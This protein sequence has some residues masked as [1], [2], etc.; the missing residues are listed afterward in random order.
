M[1]GL[2]DIVMR[3][4]DAGCD[5]QLIADM[6]DY[7]DQ[8]I[9]GAQAAEVVPSKGAE[10][11][12]RWREKQKASQNVTCDVTSDVTGD[13]S[14]ETLPSPDVPPF[15]SPKPPSHNPPLPPIQHDTA[16]GEFALTGEIL[17]PSPSPTTAKARASP[18]RGTRLPA[19]WRPEPNE[20]EFGR[21]VGLT[22]DQIE[23]TAD[24][25]RDYW[26]GVP[27]NR[28]VKLDWAATFRNRIRQTADRLRRAGG[29]AASGHGS[30]GGGRLGAYQRA[31]A[32]YS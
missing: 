28:G 9:A 10:R 12:R 13:V 31:A 20:I 26:V 18:S 5:R 1:S 23:R 6:L 14:A 4:M 7:V 22:D 11:T 16:A 29:N 25:F 17:P 3:M 32:R 24:E 8:R 15:P 21:S 27:G 19:D 2:S 30:P